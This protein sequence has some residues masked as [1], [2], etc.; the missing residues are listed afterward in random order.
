MLTTAVPFHSHV[1]QITSRRVV[2]NTRRTLL[3]RTLLPP[4]CLPSRDTCTTRVLPNST[5]GALP[6]SHPR[7]AFIFR[8]HSDFCRLLEPSPAGRQHGVCLPDLPCPRAAPPNA[9]AP[10]ITRFPIMFSPDCLPFACSSVTYTAAA[11]TGLARQAGITE[12]A[13]L[14]AQTALSLYLIGTNS[15]L[16]SGVPQQ[17]LPADGRHLH[18]P[19]SPAPAA[20]TTHT[21]WHPHRLRIC[22][23]DLGPLAATPSGFL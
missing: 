7:L 6:C 15:P 13:P 19:R 9:T 11:H 1:G 5:P 17:Q 10:R 8:V 4:T 3:S 22:S 18:N 23:C 16:V 21:A 12:T 20:P 14:A 2:A